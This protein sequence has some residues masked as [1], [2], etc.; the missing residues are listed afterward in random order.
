MLGVF[1]RR[2]ALVNR[3]GGIVMVGAGILLATGELTRITAE[4]GADWN[5]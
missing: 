2:G 5:F 3:I 1:K 4:L